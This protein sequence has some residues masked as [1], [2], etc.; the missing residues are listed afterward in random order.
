MEN[1]KKYG[2]YT[3]LNRGDYVGYVS[4]RQY[5]FDAIVKT[6]HR[7]DSVTVR[8]YF[9]LDENRQPKHGCFMGDTFRVERD[10]LF[11]LAEQYEARKG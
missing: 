2:L 8:I 9:P 5:E 4:G 6:V 11:S 3:R 1:D 10:Q 7:D